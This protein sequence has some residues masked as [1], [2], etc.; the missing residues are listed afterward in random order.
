MQSLVIYVGGCGF[1]AKVGATESFLLIGDE[2][3]IC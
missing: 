1:D 2:V 3:L